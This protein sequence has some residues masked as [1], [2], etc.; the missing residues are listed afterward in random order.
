MYYS[1]LFPLEEVTAPASD[2][3]REQAWP[4]QI[5]PTKPAPFARQTL[6]DN[7][8]TNL[9]PEFESVIR[10]SLKKLKP[11]TGQFIPPSAEG[12]IIYPGFDGGGEWGGA[13]HDPN[14]GILYVNSN[15][16]PWVLQMRKIDPAED[17]GNFSIGQQV[18]YYNCANCHG[19]DRQGAPGYP[20]LIDIDKRKTRE[21][22]KQTVLN[23]GSRM[24][25]FAHLEPEEIETAVGF[26]FNDIQS[27]GSG[28]ARE[29]VIKYSHRGYNK[30]YNA[31]GYPAIKPPWGTLNAIDLNTGEYLWRVPLGEHEALVARGIPPTGTENYG[32]PVATASGLIF[33]G[34]SQ[35][36]ILVRFMI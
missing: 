7:N 22:V 9:S 28:V 35:D 8:V 29:P 6:L 3:D 20:R 14:T 2:L 5:L 11:A 25:G 19:F 30:F 27:R 36:E 32:G 10:D 24:P 23:G 1:F 4:T 21:E 34:A 13:A 12:T 33:I 31:N 16:M 26:L 18:Y 15:E 17:M